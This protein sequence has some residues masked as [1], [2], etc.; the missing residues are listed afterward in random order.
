MYVVVKMRALGADSDERRKGRAQR[1]ELVRRGQQEER[2]VRR[3]PP[4]A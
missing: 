1:L 2:K 4:A 3:P